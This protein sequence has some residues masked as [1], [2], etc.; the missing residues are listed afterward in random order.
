MS[1]SHILF[2][3]AED[4]IALLTVNRPQKLNALNRAVMS[5]LDD[6]IGRAAGD[7]LIRGLIVTG[8]GEKAFVAGADIGEIAE[9]SPALA[10]EMSLRGQHIFRRLETLRKPSI[11]A[12]NGWALGGGLELALSCTLRIAVPGAKMGQPEVKLGILAGYGGTQRLPRLVGRGRA[13]ELLLTGEP[14]DATE[15]QRIG[16][17]NH[18]VEPAELIDFARGLLRK[19]FCNGPLAVALSMQAVDVGLNCG[20]EEGLR[21][22]AAAFGVV[23]AT[24]DRREGTR[25][26]LEKRAPVFS[27][28]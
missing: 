1:Y 27:G 21:Y 18:I 11:A 3:T 23:S 2:E 8:S 14:I 22:E 13:L 17:V 5:E 6:A 15:A 20:L 28:K 19:I 24:E 4:G 26:F 12:I 25:A 9:T 7:H 10:Q 16:L